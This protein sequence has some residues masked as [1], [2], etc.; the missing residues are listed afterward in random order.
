MTDS[1]DIYLNELKKS[2]KNGAKIK[3]PKAQVETLKK[4]QFLS[5]CK[6]SKDI[7]E[8]LIR[9]CQLSSV[10]KILHDGENSAT[11][12]GK[13]LTKDQKFPQDV[14]IKIYKKT[15]KMT[16][17]EIV[18]GSSLRPRSIIVHRE[19]NVFVMEKLKNSKTLEEMIKEN[20]S[21]IN[22]YCK[23]VL[24]LI[25][26]AQHY[27]Y[28]FW[29]SKLLAKHNVIYCDGS[30]HCLNF[31]TRLEYY[32]DNGTRRFILGNLVQVLE[33]FRTHGI[34]IEELWEIFHEIHRGCKIYGFECYTSHA[35]E[36]KY[37]IENKRNALEYMK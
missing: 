9:K 5:I 16:D 34:K 28:N 30:W 25:H 26:K 36:Q 10:E 35:I 6:A 17:V 12:C 2:N 13:F 37:F 32:Y 11:L 3:I 7:L 14:I 21:K 19:G 29:T 8:N 4:V 31:D 20:P 23:E 33:I 1:S 27:N 22:E 15:P 24:D 18:G